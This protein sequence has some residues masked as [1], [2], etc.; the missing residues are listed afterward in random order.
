MSSPM[1]VSTV[2]V[3]AISSV[4]VTTWE[5]PRSDDVVSGMRKMPSRAA[6]ASRARSEVGR[7]RIARHRTTSAPRAAGTVTSVVGQSPT[8]EGSRATYAQA[9]TSAHRWRPGDPGG[10][11]RPAP[12]PQRR[13]GRGDRHPR[14]RPDLRRAHGLRHSGG[15]VAAILASGLYVWLRAD[16]ID[17]VGWGEFSGL[18]A[19][20]A[21]SYL[22]FGA[23]GGWASRTL[24][25]SFDKL[26][27]YDHVDDPPGST[28]PGSCST[29]SISNAPG[30]RATRRCS[31]SCRSSSRPAA[32]DQLPVRR[33]RRVLR[34]LGVRL[35]ASVRDVDRVAHGTDGRV[36]RIAAVLPETAAGGARC[37]RRPVRG[38]DRRSSCGRTTS[39]SDRRLGDAP[40]T[41]PGD[42]PGLAAHLDG[43][44]RDRCRR[45]RV[46]ETRRA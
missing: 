29:T 37:S 40:L 23:I 42:E 4:H 30:A 2:S 12:R 16:V 21:L 13:P 28:M 35:H 20:R 14:V 8:T 38:G 18:A 27:L 7:R 15:V 45:A 5:R 1:A 33:R 34:E 41:L 26:D 22:L 17:V 24:E 32:L 36:H 11:D 39:T 10:A 3:A 31:R 43:M 44:G 6:V 9:R 19:T 25:Q 46:G